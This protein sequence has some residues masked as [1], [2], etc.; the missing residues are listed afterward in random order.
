MK[1]TLN[2]RLDYSS[3]EIDPDLLCEICHEEEA[4][5]TE[6]DHQYCFECYM[7]KED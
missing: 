4:E 6:K 1:Q 5:I 2:Y 7:K 3:P